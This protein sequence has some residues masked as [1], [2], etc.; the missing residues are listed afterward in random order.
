[1]SC[2]LYAN[3]CQSLKDLNHFS[4]IAQLE[5]IFAK[6]DFFLHWKWMEATLVLHTGLV[7]TFSQNFLYQRLLRPER[8]NKAF[9]GLPNRISS[10]STAEYT[11]MTSEL[12]L[13]N[14]ICIIA[15]YHLPRP[16]TS[17]VV[18]HQKE[19]RVKRICLQTSSPRS[20]C[21]CEMLKTNLCFFEVTLKRM[22]VH[23]A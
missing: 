3:Y 8:V 17:G 21:T 6:N 1:M 14:Y 16:K 4:S 5:G 11:C 10:G 22:Y 20:F 7:T 19:A 15:L 9:I 13:L 2:C 23:S 12:Y 18:S